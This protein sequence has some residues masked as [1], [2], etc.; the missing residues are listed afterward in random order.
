ML[1][2]YSMTED[3]S[4]SILREAENHFET[5]IESYWKLIDEKLLE[6]SSFY[7]YHRSFSIGMQEYIE[8]YCFWYFLKTGHLC[9][10]RLLE[11]RFQE[12]NLTHLR[13]TLEDYVAGI[14]DMSGEIMRRAN[15]VLSPAHLQDVL[16]M[17]EFLHQLEDGLYEVC[18]HFTS[19]RQ[20]WCMIQENVRKVESSCYSWKLR[21]FD[22]PYSLDGSRQPPQ[23]NRGFEVFRSQDIIEKSEERFDS[24]PMD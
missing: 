3:N 2:L 12:A 1:L 13:I 17:V 9:D 19:L 6:V 18:H 21:E 14:A 4:M 22:I 16:K 5:I 23:R 15:S 24:T 8:A 11:H 7:R 10:Q 20:K